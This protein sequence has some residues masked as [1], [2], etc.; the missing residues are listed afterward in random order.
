[1]VF[2]EGAL[3]YGGECTGGSVL[4]MLPV[5]WSMGDC[6]AIVGFRSLCQTDAENCPK[7]NACEF[8]H[9]VGAGLQDKPARLFNVQVLF[10]SSITCTRIHNLSF[11]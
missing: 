9:F 7:L 5:W 4:K 1:M 8:T 6:D 3:Q 10:R 11:R 2:A